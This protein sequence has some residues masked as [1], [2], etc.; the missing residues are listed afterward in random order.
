MQVHEVARNL[1]VTPDTVR[2]YTRAGLLEPERNPEN[3]YKEYRKQDRHRLRFILSAR[4]LGFSVSDIAQILEHA[5]KG[6]S[7]CQLVRQLIE[8]RLGEVNKRFDD[9]AKLKA[10]METAV[11]AW[12]TEPDHAPT[13]E[14]ICYLIESFTEE[15]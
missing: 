10:R 15:S 3:S 7:P 5:D 8:G 6:E 2:Y 14:M 4:H 11:E 9:M 12:S 1:G 13:G